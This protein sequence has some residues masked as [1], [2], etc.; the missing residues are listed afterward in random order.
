MEI[1]LFAVASL[2]VGVLVGR[3]S[4]VLIP[5]LFFLVLYP[6]SRTELADAPDTSVLIAFAGAIGCGICVFLG[7]AVRRLTNRVRSSKAD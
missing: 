4:A 2:L 3:M 7:V 5:A 6:L 1:A